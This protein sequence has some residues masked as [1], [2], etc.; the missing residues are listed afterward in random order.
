MKCALRFIIL[1]K[2]GLTC[3]AQR[4]RWS[5]HIVPV[6]DVSVTSFTPRFFEKISKTLHCVI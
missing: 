1:R 4:H 5:S 2:L 3:P 6:L